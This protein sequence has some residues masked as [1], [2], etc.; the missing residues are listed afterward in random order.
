MAA[1]AAPLDAPERSTPDAGRARRYANLFFFETPV[2]SPGVEE[3]V[4]GLARI[5]VGHL[6]ELAPGRNEGVDRICD[7]ILHDGDFLTP[8][9]VT[10]P[11][12]ATEVPLAL[13]V[14]AR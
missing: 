9:G 10:F 14:G 6:D 3:H 13:A 12:P 5:T 11:E 4:L 2:P 7:G 1:L 8:V